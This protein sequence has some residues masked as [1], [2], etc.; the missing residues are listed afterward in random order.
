MRARL[1]LTVWYVVALTL[2]LAACGD[3]AGDD[4]PL[5]VVATSAP[6]DRD[7]VT[8]EH[9]S[10]VFVLRMPPD[11]VA[12]DL[13]DPNGVRVQFTSLEGDQAMT[14]LSA[15]VVNT[16]QPMTPEALAQAVDAY[17]PPDDMAAYNWSE[18][19]R[20]GQRDGS[21]RIRGVRTYPALGPRSMNIFLQGD[22]AF[23]SALEV[24]V[25]GADEETLHTLRTVINTFRV[26]VDAE[27]EVGVVQQARV[28][29]TSF[30]GVVAF[31]GYTAWTDRDGT[32]HITG[33]VINTT[34]S[35]LEAL[36][37]SAV[38][39]DSQDRRLAEQSDILSMDVLGP[40]QGAPFDLRFEEGKPPT[41]VRYDLNV[42]ARD[43][44]YAVETFYGTDNF[45][46]AN[47]EAVYNDRGNLVVR[48]E[49]ANVG[50][51]LATAV[52]IIVAIWNDQGQVVATETVFVPKTQLVPQEA[53]T[54]EVTFYELGG[55]AV[56][57]TLTVAG[58]VG[59]VPPG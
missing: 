1:V 27:L 52:K 21:Q 12:G 20:V 10:G 3:L 15:Y 6:A 18:L 50:P 41:T 2:A 58:T 38:L 19:D 17:Q 46:V 9:P 36:R 29:V 37:L 56:T 42:A 32:F 51:S 13:P 7:F 49:L 40:G 22:G 53:T 35:P 33:E 14:R 5:I 24:D 48:G 4:E 43:A 45:V 16:G 11:W 54:F 23:F 28:G 31:N 47:D 26:N 57:Y 59:E 55:A 44:L 39:Y 34:A 25:T 8:Y 30:S